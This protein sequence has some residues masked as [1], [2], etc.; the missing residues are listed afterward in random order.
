MSL[1]LFDAFDVEE[2]VSSEA[3]VPGVEL[4]ALGLPSL[5]AVVALAALEAGGPVSPALTALLAVP[6]LDGGSLAADHLAGANGAAT[7]PALDSSQVLV[8]YLEA[9]LVSAAADYFA[10]GSPSFSA[11]AA[12]PAVAAPA[13]ADPVLAALVSPLGVDSSAVAT[14]LDAI[15]Q[16]VQVGG[17]TGEL[18]APALSAYSTSATLD[19]LELEVARLELRVLVGGVVSGEIAA[20]E[21]GASVSWGV[22]DS[23]ELGEPHTTALL[24]LEAVN[25][26]EGA[27]HSSEALLHV[28]PYDG[29]TVLPADTIA[30]LGAVVLELLELGAPTAWEL[31]APYRLDLSSYHRPTVGP[32]SHAH[33]LTGLTPQPADPG[34]FRLLPTGR[35]AL[36]GP[37]PHET[38]KTGLTPPPAPNKPFRFNQR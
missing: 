27:P 22:V 29:A 3:T 36:G 24:S 8:P 11:A 32:T 10:Y 28:V 15:N 19:A 14:P 33:L 7:P 16:L 21:L 30:V 5:L 38:A 25:A 13:P 1:L 26:F 18:A 20:G 4:S 35:K 12:A 37:E 23:L 6:A 34:V 9:Q 17:V 2:A 31:P